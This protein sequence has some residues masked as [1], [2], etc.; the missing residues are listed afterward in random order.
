ME[1]VLR[2]DRPFDETDVDVGRVLL[3]VDERAVDDVRALGDLEQALIHV[4]ERHVAARAAVKPDRGEP[5]L[6]HPGSASRPCTWRY[7]KNGR[8]SLLPSAMERPFS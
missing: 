4:E 2:R 5:R 3:R 1:I 7:G 8:R 6:A